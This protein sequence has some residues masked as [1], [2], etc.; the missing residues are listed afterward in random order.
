MIQNRTLKPAPFYFRLAFAIQTLMWC[1]P[2]SLSAYFNIS[3]FP[4]DST[5][6][7]QASGKNTK[8]AEYPVKGIAVK[9]IVIDAGHGGH[10]PGCL[11]PNIYEKDI[12]LGIA[13]K[14]ATA[15]STQHPDVQV[16]LTRNDD[17]FIPLHER[18]QIA[19]RAAADLFISIHCN[20]IRKAT[21]VNGSETY[22]LGPHKLEE[23]L[24]VALRENSVVLHEENYESVYGYDP[25]SPEATIIMSMY[26]N[27]YLEQSI[28]F[29]DKVEKHMETSANRHSRGVKQAG[30]L[31]LRETTMPSVLIETGFLSNS[32]EVD[33][34]R[35]EDGQQQI[36]GAILDAFSDYKSD[37]EGGTSTQT[38]T[39]KP[40]PAPPPP[41][42]AV[43]VASPPAQ[44]KENTSPAPSPQSPPPVYTAP[45][46]APYKGIIFR[47]QVAAS[48]TLLDLRTGAWAQVTYPIEIVT[49]NGMTK[50][51]IPA[52]S[53]L[54][55]AQQIQQQMRDLG[56]S[57]AFIVAYQYGQKITVNDAK[58]QLG[59]H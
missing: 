20:Y 9:K 59:I 42:A 24:Q 43:P 17:T 19:N 3:L 49:E 40:V 16:I 52:S 22:V 27:A 58:Q 41:P 25:N 38:T 18:A 4:V 21:H 34:L 54:W 2:P 6:L 46:S 14:L 26:Q 7:E 44:T 39:A 8:P 55:Q 48:A 47:V 53:G 12:A 51:Q 37:L 28:L 36:A 10:D 45:A 30:F 57:D 35:T 23:N 31:V 32:Q 11:G 1:F 33:Y 5:R 56:F 15:I 50:Y 29:A 13:L